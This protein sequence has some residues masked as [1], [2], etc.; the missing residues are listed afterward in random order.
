MVILEL[1]VLFC[2]CSYYSVL[3]LNSLLNASLRVSNFRPTHWL[4]IVSVVDFNELFQTF[5]WVVMDGSIKCPIFWCCCILSEMGGNLRPTKQ[6]SRG[7][8]S[9]PPHRAPSNIV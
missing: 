3:A 9:G 4:K 8:G 1:K 7:S 2:G 5:F 6:S